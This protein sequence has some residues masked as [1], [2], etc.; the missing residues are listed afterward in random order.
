MKPGRVKALAVVGAP[1]GAGGY[2]LAANRAAERGATRRDQ[3]TVAVERLAVGE[4]RSGSPRPA[5][6][7]PT[8]ALA[9]GSA[10]AAQPA[11]TLCRR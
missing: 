3:E 6:A 10:R 4:V 7:R 5:I 9:V 8:G 2:L 1:S 11:P